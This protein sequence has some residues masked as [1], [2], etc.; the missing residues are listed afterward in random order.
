MKESEK[1]IENLIT[2]CKEASPVCSPL[3][4]QKVSKEDAL[5]ES[6]REIEILNTKTKEQGNIP[7]VVP[8]PDCAKNVEEGKNCTPG[9]V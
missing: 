5:K 7:E 9:K 3:P 6:E 2:K 4:F 1:Q 8:V